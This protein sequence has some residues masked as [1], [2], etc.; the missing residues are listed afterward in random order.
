MTTFTY[1]QLAE[2]TPPLC[3]G[4]AEPIL[5]D[6]PMIDGFAQITRDHQWIHV[7][8]VRAATG[9]FGMTIAHGYLTLS[10]VS[11]FLVQ[12]FEVADV[13]MTVNYGLDRVRFPQPV[14]VNSILHGECELTGVE[15]RGG[16][17]ETT[18]RVTMRTDGGIDK[19]ACIADVVVRVMP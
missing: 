4:S 9:P 8:P 10:L 17:L 2:S 18:I 12:C 14:P 6:Q 13:S 19:P 1:R 16:G 5:V 15:A 11:A 7:D 3:L